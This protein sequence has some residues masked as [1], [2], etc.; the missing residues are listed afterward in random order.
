[1]HIQS[2]ITNSETYV[3]NARDLILQ[4]KIY[5]F[6][7]NQTDKLVYLL[8]S[9]SLTINTCKIACGSYIGNLIIRAKAA[10]GL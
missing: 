3:S 8:D 5:I 10:I 2:K 4:A 1:M 9:A 6:P 7:A